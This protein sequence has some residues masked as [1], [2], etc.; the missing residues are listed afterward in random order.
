MSALIPVGTQVLVTPVTITCLDGTQ[1]TDPP[2]KAIVVG[3]DLHRTK[4]R[5]DRQ[6]WAGLYAS[7]GHTWA[8]LKEVAANPN[9][10]QE[11]AMI[12]PGQVLSRVVQTCW[13]CPSQWDAW[14]REGEYLYLR[15]RWGVGTVDDEEGNELA[16]FSTGDPYGGVI[17]FNEFADRA[18]LTVLDDARQN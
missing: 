10:T 17:S 3:Y 7:G 4:Y 16:R 8:F 18:G 15:Y 12:Q 13:G 1:T 9:T 5:L 2:Y 14:T 11:P 6:I